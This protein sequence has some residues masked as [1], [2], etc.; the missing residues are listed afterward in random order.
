MKTF[1]PSKSLLLLDSICHQL[2]P[3]KGL[4]G[5]GKEV[6]KFQ[7]A[8]NKTEAGNNGNATHKPCNCLRWQNLLNVEINRKPSD[9]KRCYVRFHCGKHITAKGCK[10]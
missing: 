1:D 7:V 8:T 6:P 5:A 9:S 3:G 10:K 2:R 4:Q